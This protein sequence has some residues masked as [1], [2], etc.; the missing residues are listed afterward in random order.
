MGAE[1]IVW[2]FRDGEPASLQFSDVIGAFGEAVHDWDP[3]SG[4]LH[5]EYD[6]EIDSCDIFCGKDA[7]E[8]GR[9]R[10]LLI[11]RPVANP[12][13]WEAVLKIMSL[14]HVLLFFSYDTTPRFWDIASVSHFP[15]DLIAS[16]GIPVRVRTPQDIA[17]CGVSARESN[18]QSVEKDQKQPGK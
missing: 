10:S 14:G 8:T 16:L 12:R 6:S 1:A 5:V 18:S 15:D 17:I 3:V 9:V 11:D 7:M 13:M 4:R 2:I